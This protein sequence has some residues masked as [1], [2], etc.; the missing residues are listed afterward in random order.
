M[1]VL[2]N[3]EVDFIET[4]RQQPEPGEKLLIDIIDK[5][6]EE[7]GANLPA[8]SIPLLL[9][10]PE[11]FERHIDE[12]PWDAKRHHTHACQNCGHCWRPAVVD[13][14]GVRFLPGFKNAAS[15]EAVST[16]TSGGKRIRMV[17][18]LPAPSRDQEP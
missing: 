6:Q 4:T 2:S 13:T 15:A 3:E 5:L 17:G 18:P 1:T 10:C 7:E 9:H 16:P 11:C 8:P 12:A 14:V